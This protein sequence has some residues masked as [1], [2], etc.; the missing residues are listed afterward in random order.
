MG[1]S[2]SG[3]P[4][5]P[6]A[7]LAGT[8][9]LNDAPRV[10]V[11]RFLV[12][13]LFVGLLL[14]GPGGAGIAT[15]AT[16]AEPAGM[17]TLTSRTTTADGTPI[18]E[19]VHVDRTPGSQ[20][21]V[22]VGFTYEIPDGVAALTVRLPV[23][24]RTDATVVE[25]DGFDRNADGGFEWN[26]RT[27]GPTITVT[28]SVSTDRLAPDGLGIER[29]D[30]AF[31]YLPQTAVQWRYRGMNPGID[32]RTAVEGEGIATE[33]MAFTGNH[34]LRERTAGDTPVTVVVPEVSDPA[35]ESAEV[36]PV[37]ETGFRHLAGD[38]IPRLTIVVLPAARVTGPEGAALGHSF[39]VRDE[40]FAVDRPE[41]VP[42][43]EFVHTRLDATRYR[44]PEWIVEG[45]AN[46]YA[47]LLAL[48]HGAVGF[49]AFHEGVTAERF[50]PNRTTVVLADPTTYESNLGEYEKGA[51]VL[52]ALDAQIRRR[53]G[54]E[55]TLEDLFTAYR[56]EKHDNLTTYDGIVGATIDLTGDRSME[57]WL[58]R[59]VRTDA[60]PPLPNN[61]SLYVMNGSIDSDDDG[62]SNGEETARNTAPF[63][64]DTDGD[65]LEDG[66]EVAEYGTNATRNDTDGD[67][68]ED[69]QE[70]MEFGTDPTMADTDDDGLMDGAEITEYGSD[71]TDPDTDGDGLEDGEDSRPTVATT[72][73]PTS[74][75]TPPSSTSEPPASDG[76][77]ES[78]T[79]IETATA[80]LSG[81]GVS[82]EETQVGDTAETHG[83]GS[84][85]DRPIP[86]FGSV[87]ALAALVLLFASLLWRTRSPTGED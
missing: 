33:T 64:N 3:H 62:L 66:A 79:T 80:V 57:D 67:G 32:R 41:N 61:Q 82:P 29:T 7:S 73:T 13:I 74:T 16:G 86:G 18:V 11:N 87:V 4:C 30:W 65:G 17:E 26:E 27:T 45:R 14:G 6:V 37:L 21:T 81:A 2:G 24:D 20:G 78:G 23:L 83:T 68:L 84:N 5:S 60:L 38:P 56:T 50:R 77:G 72:P 59:Y 34:Q 44:P 35:R 69:G 85:A 31:L 52:A 36:L 1:A 40:W 48:N 42:A 54:G 43:H 28:L 55:H 25:T 47:A 12:G 63:A 8:P 10:A 75:A 46:Y 19:R 15:G 76:G 51:H 70:V 49:E 58:D 9:F 71:P 39:W 53:T 22:R